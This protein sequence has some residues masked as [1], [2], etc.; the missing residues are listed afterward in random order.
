M[1]TKRGAAYG[2][3]R[4]RKGATGGGKRTAKALG[5]AR[6][7]RQGTTTGNLWGYRKRN[8]T[9]RPGHTK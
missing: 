2:G 9:G 1:A 3:K 6:P 8:R 7:A 5:N 4:Q